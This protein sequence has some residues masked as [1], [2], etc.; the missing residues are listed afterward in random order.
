MGE[1]RIGE[2]SSADY[3]QRLVRVYFSEAEMMSGWLKVIKS[4]PFI[5]PDG[6]EKDVISGGS[7]D[8][9]NTAGPLAAHRHGLRIVPWF[10]KIGDKVL[11]IYNSGFNED[12]FV[13]GGI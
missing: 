11:C 7:A 2:V 12:G 9:T 10:P 1:I 3:D 13:I 5:V 4:P 8:E 6:T